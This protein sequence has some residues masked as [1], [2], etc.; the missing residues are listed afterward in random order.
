VRITRD[1]GSRDVGLGTTEANDPAHQVA[2]RNSLDLPG[3]V[4]VDVRVRRVSTLPAPV[5]PAYAELA[6]RVGWQATPRVTLA[7]VG[8]DVLHDHHAE[9]NPV[10]RGYEEFQRSI[11]AVLTVRSR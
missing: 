11:R 5:V 4:E 6:F 2:F 9:F 8:E 3:D 1:A 7:L 10:P